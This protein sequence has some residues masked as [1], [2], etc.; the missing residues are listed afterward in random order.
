MM[1]PAQSLSAQDSPVG[2][3]ITVGNDGI[4]ENSH[5][6]VYEK[7]GLLYGKI[8]KLLKAPQNQTCE[9]C[10]GDKKGK[11][12]LGMEIINGLKKNGTQYSGGELIDP[13]NGKTYKCKLW[14]DHNHLKV[15][16]YAAFFFKTQTWYPVEQKHPRGRTSHIYK[17]MGNKKFGG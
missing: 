6:Q 5:V 7:N 13:E 4:T 12:L 9:I 17:G 1:I 15:R 16:G 3:W 10:E 2:I 8:V 11:P 14:R